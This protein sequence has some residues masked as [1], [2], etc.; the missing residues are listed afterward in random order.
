MVALDRIVD[1]L[2]YFWLLINCLRRDH[3]TSALSFPV[4]SYSC[5]VVQGKL[6]LRL[7]FQYFC[8]ISIRREINI[9]CLFPVRHF[10]LKS[11][12]SIIR[13]IFIDLCSN[14]LIDLHLTKRLSIYALSKRKDQSFP[15]RAQKL[16]LVQ[17][18]NACDVLSTLIGQ[19]IDGEFEVILLW[20][21]LE[22]DLLVEDESIV[23]RRWRLASDKWA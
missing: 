10:S 14:N 13:N 5:V 20:F 12:L 8:W 11:A 6:I 23:I 3:A 15:L 7:G 9:V 17:F 16:S 18:N 19:Q 21:I 22:D 1:L 2:W 4:M